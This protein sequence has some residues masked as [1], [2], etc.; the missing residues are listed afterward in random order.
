MLTENNLEKYQQ[1]IAKAVADPNIQLAMS[2]ALQANGR[3]LDKVWARYPDTDELAKKVREI[4]QKA[5]PQMESLYARA[6]QTLEEQGGHAYL[7]QTKDGLYKALSE[8][9]GTNKMIVKTKSVLGEE[10]DLRDYLIGAGHEVWETDLGELIFQLQSKHTHQLAPAM[11]ISREQVAEL[12][13]EFFGKPVPPDIPAQ[14]ALVREFLRDKFYNADIGLSS[15]NAVAADSGAL[16]II[17]GEGNV[18]LATGFPPVHVAVVG[19]EKLVPTLEEALQVVTA[20]WRHAGFT[21]PPY[22][23]IIGSPSK[24]QDIER[25]LV[26][27]VHGPAELHVIFVDNGRLEML[28]SPLFREALF[29]LRC[30]GCNLRC[31]VFRVVGSRFG[32]KYFGGIGAVWTAFTDGGIETAMPLIYTCLRCGRCVEKCPV[33]IDIPSMIG[34]LRKRFINEN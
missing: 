34:E 8:I 2:R 27:G 21:M 19:L 30:S 22:V 16:V 6:K 13:S 18:R 26:Q 31:P 15:A 33:K 17:E 9:I 1:D 29:C 14:T 24:T 5:I 7:V 12:F 10:V 3:A 4:K 25:V 28:K 20:T 23:N 11:D 32:R